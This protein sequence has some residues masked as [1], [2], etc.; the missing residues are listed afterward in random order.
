MTTSGTKEDYEAVRE[1]YRAQKEGI[2]AQIAERQKK[3]LGEQIEISKLEK[4]L[5]DA[6]PRTA[7]GERVCEKCD[8]TSMAPDGVVPGQG[9]R[10]YWYKCEVCGHTDFEM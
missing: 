8:I 4:K 5:E 6:R 3:V 1:A 7:K 10:E 9:A 2:K